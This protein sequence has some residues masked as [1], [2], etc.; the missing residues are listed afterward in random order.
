MA[1]VLVVDDEELIRLNLVAYLED[2]EI[3]TVSTTSGEDAL[4]ILENQGFDV[5]IIDMRLPGINGNELIVAANRRWPDMRFIIHTGSTEYRLPQGL[6][7][8]GIDD[9]HVFL[10][11]LPDMGKLVTLVN[12]FAA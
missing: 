4:M 7:D 5:G 9:S 8:L 3:E 12:A 10:K 1:S 11:P 6:V 2:D